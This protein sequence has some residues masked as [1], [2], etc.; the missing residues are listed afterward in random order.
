MLTVAACLVDQGARTTD[1]AVTTAGDVGDRTR[2]LVTAEPDFV[3][4]SF[5]TNSHQKKLG[6]EC[7]RLQWALLEYLL[8]Q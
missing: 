8:P 6:F 1:I 5:L 7:Q 4:A 2:V 3:F